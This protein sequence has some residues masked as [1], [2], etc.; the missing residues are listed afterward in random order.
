MQAEVGGWPSCSPW[1][2]RS[3]PEQVA[4][5]MTTTT[6]GVAGRPAESDALTKVGKGEGKVSLIAWAGYVEDGSTDPAVDWVTPLRGQDRLPGERQGG[7]HLRRDGHPD[8]H[9]QVRR[10]LGLRRRDAPPHRRRRRRPGEHGP[11]AQLQG[12]LPGAQGQ[13]AQHGRRGQLRN[14]ARSRGQPP[15]VEHRGGQAATGLVGRGL[16]RRVEVQGTRDGLRQPDLHRGRRSVSQGD[17]A[18]AGDRQRLRARPGAVRR[19]RGPAEG[20]SARTSASTGR[21]TPRSRR[22]SPAA[23]R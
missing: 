18:R 6:A 22:R 1:W 23:T 3:S 19:G 10:G 13:A 21:T 12:H 4:A 2:R 5:T 16:R 17:E 14:P 7:Q 15:H 8:A 20:A 11:R 9:R